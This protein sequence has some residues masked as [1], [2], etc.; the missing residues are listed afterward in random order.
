MKVKAEGVK[1]SKKNTAPCPLL[2]FK[3]CSACGN[4]L[5][6][7]WRMFFKVELS[8]GRMAGINALAGDTTALKKKKEGNQLHNC[9]QNGVHAV[10]KKI[11]STI[12]LKVYLW[13]AGTILDIAHI[14]SLLVMTMEFTSSTSFCDDE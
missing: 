2:L 3:P 5:L 7:V 11:K 6:T 12:V 8:R 1:K 14:K 10:I 9:M 4:T 13:A